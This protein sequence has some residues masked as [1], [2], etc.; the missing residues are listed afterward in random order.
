MPLLS[1][2]TYRTGWRER[3]KKKSSG[4]L[5]RTNWKKKMDRRRE[6]ERR[7]RERR[8]SQERE[9]FRDKGERKK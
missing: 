2:D 1:I 4:I 5:G 3:G 7:E 8:G 9:K 6:R